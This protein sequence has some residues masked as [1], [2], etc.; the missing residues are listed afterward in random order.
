MFKKIVLGL[1]LLGSVLVFTGCANHNTTSA[2]TMIDVSKVEKYITLGTTTLQ[3][4]RELLGTPTISGKT[5]DGKDFVGFSFIGERGYGEGIA[6]GVGHILSFGIVSDNESYFTQKNLY[7]VL[8]ENKIVQNFKYNGY[9]YIMHAGKIFRWNLAQRE[10]N[11]SELRSS[12]KFSKDYII[13]AWKKEI[14]ETQP[15]IAK[16]AAE[17]E[18]VSIE[19]L[20]YDDVEYACSGFPAY[21]Q[22]GAHKAFGDYTNEELNTIGGKQPYDGSKKALLGL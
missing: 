22:F 4:T 13:N 21:L 19:E 14:V 7:F 17:K 8:D 11:D 15:K 2:D 12:T 9:S 10:L 20:E 3:E 18:K 16:K 6:R 1:G 5:L